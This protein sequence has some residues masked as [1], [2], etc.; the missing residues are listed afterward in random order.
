MS[1]EMIDPDRIE[2]SDRVQAASFA[3]QCSRYLHH[4]IWQ[5]DMCSIPSS[6]QATGVFSHQTPPVNSWTSLVAQS[7]S[8]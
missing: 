6:Y 5:R 2:Q 4:L 8:F 3:I 7:D 1:P